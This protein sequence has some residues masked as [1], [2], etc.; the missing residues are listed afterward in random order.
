MKNRE[1]IIL[2]YVSFLAISTLLL[3]PSL[4]NYIDFYRAIEKCQINLK[5]AELDVT[6]LQNGRVSLLAVFN[7]SNPTNFKNLKVTSI[8]CNIQ[9]SMQG[10]YRKLPGITRVFQK[11]IEIPSNGYTNIN[12]NFTFEYRSEKQEVKDFFA[13]LLTNPKEISFIFQGQYVFYAYAYPFT[14]PMGPFKYTVIFC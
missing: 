14:V 6:Q 3:I 11:P 1:I 12:L 7:I 9:Y 5:S 10:S 2:I 4:S 8:T 13:F